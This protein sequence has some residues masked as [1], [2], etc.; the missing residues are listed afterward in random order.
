MTI[1]NQTAFGKDSIS[2][3]Q[4]LKVLFLGRAR[5]EFSTRCVK[6]L[7]EMG[8]ELTIVLSESRKQDLFSHV[9]EWHGDYL[10]S[11]RNL[12]VVP[13]ALL[14]QASVAAVNFHPGPP[15]YP[16]SGCLNFAL[17]EFAPTYGVTAHYMV[18]TVDEG[19][20]IDCRRFPIEP[21]DNVDSLLAKTHE[22]LFG[23]FVDFAREVLPKGS[24]AL[25][26]LAS[27]NSN[28]RWSGKRRKMS[29]IDA[30]QQV[31]VDISPE[32]L[33][34]I[35]RSTHTE[36]FP[37]VLDLHGKKFAL[38]SDPRRMSGRY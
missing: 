36:E 26:E 15:E 16:G 27:K 1:R 34:R 13:K 6:L 35:I 37:V 28:Q 3:D 32:E 8:L 2:G 20:I 12:Y 4:N 31:A 10:L 38:V 11:F 29:E 19:E 7:E 24:N 21:D 30:L 17:Y 9:A 22:A 18:E 5:C 23:L 33:S 25:D 14:D